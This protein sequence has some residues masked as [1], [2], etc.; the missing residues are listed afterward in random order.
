MF[1]HINATLCNKL[2]MN[3]TKSGPTRSLSCVHVIGPVLSGR[4]TVL[5]L[6]FLSF[7][8]MSLL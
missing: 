1:G 3:T 8:V 2:C 4:S 7:Q 5:V 6:L